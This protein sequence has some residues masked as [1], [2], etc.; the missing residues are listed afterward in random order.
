MFEDAWEGYYDKMDSYLW[1]TWYPPIINIYK[2]SQFVSMVELDEYYDYLITEDEDIEEGI[3]R[4][5]DLTDKLKL[6]IINNPN[7]TSQPERLINNLRSI[8]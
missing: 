3:N 7:S 1:V 2:N 4:I 6:W 8:L 5:K